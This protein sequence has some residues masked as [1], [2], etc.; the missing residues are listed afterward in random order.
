MMLL[1]WEVGALVPTHDIGSWSGFQK[2]S[3]N[4]SCGAE[5]RGYAS[6]WPHPCTPYGDRLGIA[7]SRLQLGHSLRIVEYRIQSLLKKATIT[8]QP[9]PLSSNS[10]RL[11]SIASMALLLPA[12]AFAHVK[13]FSKFSLSDRPAT[14]AEAVTPVFLGLVVLSV[15]VITILAITEQRIADQGWFQRVN[16]WLG[17]R[18]TQAPIVLRVVMGATLL[19]S[20]QQ[21]SVF[22]PELIVGAWVG[23]IE[24]LLAVMLLFRRTTPWA[25][26]GILALFGYCIATFGV[27]HMIDYL[28]YIGIAWYLLVVDAKDVR[29]KESRIPVLYITVGFSL[30]WLGL[31][32][33]IYPEWTLYIL[34]QNPQL[35]LGF[36][37]NFFRVGAAFVEISLAYLFLICLFERPIAALVTVVFMLT[38]MVFGKVEVIGHT[39]IHGALIVFLL[40][41]PGSFYR[42]PIAW[43]RSVAWRAAFAGVNFVLLVGLG[44]LAYS[45]MAW[46][47]YREHS[48]TD[49]GKHSTIYVMPA[50]TT[51]FHATLK[52]ERAVYS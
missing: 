48:T 46:H 47:V 26:I 8:R 11:A 43:H 6:L 24:F 18:K 21:D 29:L 10:S 19:L 3:A 28:H 12:T 50:S 2:L 22:A 17:Q 25:A 27:F 42:P 1:S 38:T 41:G 32:K 30:A 40:E 37:P 39:A 20:W 15:V 35:A 52:R 51:D 44:L 45:A 9:M 16:S 23:W 5:S 13:W 49:T 34:Q 31:E 7:E 33:I 14:I 36:D 4:R